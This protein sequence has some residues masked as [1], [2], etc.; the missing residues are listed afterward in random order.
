MIIRLEKSSGRTLCRGRACKKNPIYINPQTLRV[1]AGTTVAV[2][3]IDSA[4]GQTI[5]YYCRDCID[6]IY[7]EMKKALN[8][9]L[10]IFT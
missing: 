5:S 1:I 10:W 4:K 9:Q 7:L 8:P 3:V 6:Q 2:F